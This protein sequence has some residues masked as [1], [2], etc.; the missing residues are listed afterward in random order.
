[1]AQINSFGGM[2][3]AYGLEGLPP[4]PAT[5]VAGGR[6][7]LE[8]V[9]MNKC[10]FV[11]R[12]SLK[13]YNCGRGVVRGISEDGLTHMWVTVRCGRWVC[14]DCG[15][16]RL[17]L[18]RYGIERECVRLGINKMM[19]LTLPAKYRGDGFQQLAGAWKL[20]VVRLRR[21]FPKEKFH[22][23][24]A[25]EL[26]PDRKAPHLHVLTNKFLPQRWISKC[27]QSCGGGK[28]CD[29]RVKDVHRMAEYVTYISKEFLKDYFPSG[30]RRF[31]TSQGIKLFRKVKLT[32]FKWEFFDFDIRQAWDRFA[33]DGEPHICNG[34]FL[35]YFEKW[36]K[37]VDKG[38]ENNV[39]CEYL[40]F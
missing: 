8:V 14:P 21:R 7:S 37:D 40:P 1:M 32:G 23:I 13:N 19:T 25:V 18:V 15:P 17:K 34:G 38:Q 30:V 20:F 35:I 2:L 11:N 16:R 39:V 6:P 24:A 4:R 5:D 10:T 33:Y 29:I 26:Q 9:S 12:K 3:K 28:I 36:K 31:R 27:W 22:Y